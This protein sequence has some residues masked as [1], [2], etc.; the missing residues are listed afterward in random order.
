[1]EYE[2]LVPV[3]CEVKHLSW[4]DTHHIWSARLHLLW[5]NN[6]YLQVVQSTAWPSYDIAASVFVDMI[7]SADSEQV[8]HITHSH[9]VPWPTVIDTIA[10]ELGLEI[11][12]YDAWA[13]ALGESAKVLESVAHDQDKTEEI[14]QQNPCLRLLLFFKQRQANVESFGSPK[15]SIEKAQR[16]SRT[17]RSARQLD[18]ADVKR[19]LDYWRSIGFIENKSYLG[20][21]RNS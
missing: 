20:S 14:L 21:K 19:W 7:L 1:M 12:P 11:V 9:P 16:V 6:S 15:L 4:E 17:L 18:S 2:G 8:L 13:N 10:S 5:R 3:L